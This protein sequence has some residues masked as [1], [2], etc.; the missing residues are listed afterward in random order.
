MTDGNVTW[1]SIGPGGGVG[2]VVGWGLCWRDERWSVGGGEHALTEYKRREKKMS[3]QSEQKREREIVMLMGEGER[4]RKI[5]LMMGE[6]E[7]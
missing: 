5:V 1:E 7:K 4:E 2:W 3:R 6:R